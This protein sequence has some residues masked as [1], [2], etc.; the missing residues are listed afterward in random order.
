[1]HP[2]RNFHEADRHALAAIVASIGLASIV[3]AEGGRA[4]TAASPVL[5]SGDKARFHLSSRNKLTPILTA[6]AWALAIVM[7]EN[8]YISPDWY[9]AADQVPTWNYRSVEIE[10]ALRVMRRDETAGL[11]DDLSAQFEERLAPKRPWTRAKMRPESFEAMLGAITGFEMTIARMEG[12]FKLSQNKPADEVSRVSTRLAE[13]PD[14]GSQA[15]SALM[16]ARNTKA[17]S[18]TE[19]SI[20][21]PDDLASAPRR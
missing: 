9:A 17:P 7:S 2:A 18:T 19:A 8:A 11:L 12:T 10:G 13:R 16:S 21:P 3:G 5:L 15:I 20:A 4:V 6:S 1:L 14:A